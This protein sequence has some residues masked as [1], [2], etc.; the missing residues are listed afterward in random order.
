MLYQNVIAPY[1][2][3]TRKHA[4][5]TVARIGGQVFSYAQ[6]TQRI[7]PIMN[8]LDALS[9]ERVGVVTEPDLTA[10]AALLA[11]LF[12]GVVSVPLPPRL[13][14]SQLEDVRRELGL[15]EILTVERMHYYFRMTFE[16]ALCRVDNGL[17]H[18]DAEQLVCIRCQF[19][20]DK[21]LTTKS[22]CAKDFNR[23]TPFSLKP[24]FQL[25]IP[26]FPETCSIF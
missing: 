17:Y 3:Q 26:D 22:L 7:A 19:P 18:F 12:T 20:P 23:S 6:L 8:E 11:C 15:S 1:I 21:H 14:E 4:D 2:R 10:C 25:L 9:V 5:Q 13:P 16:D 24:V